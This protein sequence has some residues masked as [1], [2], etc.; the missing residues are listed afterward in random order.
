MRQESQCS[1]RSRHVR[2]H[3]SLRPG[4]RRTFSRLLL[5][6]DCVSYKVVCLSHARAYAFLHKASM[7]NA[8]TNPF[9]YGALALDDA[10]TDR[11]SELK[12]LAED[13]RN[14]QDVLVFAPRR[15]GKSSLVLRAAQQAVA[16][17]V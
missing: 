1:A 15:Y 4:A 7:Y 16:K 14:G 8:P 13:I 6:Y 12:E 3:S 11:D 9:I 5:I 10:F 17:K 2:P